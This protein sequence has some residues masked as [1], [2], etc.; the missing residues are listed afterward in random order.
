MWNA[1]EIAR[2]LEAAPGY[3]FDVRVAGHDWAKLKRGRDAYVLKLNGIY[4]RNLE[5]K[6]ISTV[7]A[8]ARFI[9]RNEV[10]A[11]GKTYRADHVLVAT[12]GFP[13]VPALEG[14]E[15]GITSDGF[16]D[17]ESLPKRVAVVGS[18]YIAAELGSAF[19]SLGSEVHVFVRYDGMFRNF[20]AL[21]AQHLEKD[22]RLAGVEIV[23][24]ATP[25]A[26]TREGA[27]LVLHTADG[28]EFR[29]FTTVLWAIGREPNTRGLGLER[30]E[31]PS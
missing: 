26:V 12:G 25:R 6:G 18:G 10:V 28:R 17:L 22:L 7:R 27:G 9:G 3:G 23:T 8:A 1:A 21:V 31:L 29:G 5:R 11:D 13:K 19:R 14:A 2:M 4:E 16:F 24:G 15:L 20:D 30:A